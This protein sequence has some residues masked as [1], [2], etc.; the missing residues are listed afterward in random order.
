MKKFFVVFSA[1]CFLLT[2][3]IAYSQEDTIPE[4]DLDPLRFYKPKYD[5]T[6]EAPID[7]V[8]KAV[9]KTLDDI[10]CVIVQAKEK[11]D[12]ED[13]W[14]R[15]IIKS[16]FC[17]FVEGDSSFTKL[18]EKSYNMPFIRG[19]AWKNGRMQYKFVITEQPDEKVYLLL[20]GNMSGF[21]HFVTNRVHFWESNGQF[22]HEILVS[23]ENNI[24]LLTKPAE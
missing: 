1:F 4:E 24:K 3:N 21:E 14:A 22:E 6:Y 23:I 13:G 10:S 20:T 2:C 5:A 7:I 16:D 12:D 18:R 15:W 8:A 19:G 17:V 11:T 9:K